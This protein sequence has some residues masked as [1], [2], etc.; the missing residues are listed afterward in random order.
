MPHFSDDLLL[1]RMHELCTAGTPFVAAT[2]IGTKG[3]TPRKVGAKML[4]ARDGRLFGTVGGGAVESAVIERAKKLF[5][6]PEVARL[7]WDLSGPEAGGM[8]CGGRMEFLLEPFLVRPRA[9]V[10]G[11]GHVGLALSR[12]LDFL[13][14]DVTVIDDREALMTPERFPHARL[15][16]QT[17]SEAALALDIPA[18]AYCIVV[19]RSHA[20]DLDTLRGLVRR[21]LRYVGLMSS[22][23][24]RGILLETLGKEGVAPDILKSVR[25]PVGLDI[26]A[27]TPEEIAVAIAAE[28]VGVLRAVAPAA[29]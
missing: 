9:F 18:D 24:K 3:S 2:V 23:R 16:Q 29:P 11:A 1:T 5:A 6:A 4:V 10:F 20:F 22:K 27:E 17:P 7:D 8:I 28:M 13:H 19:N 21:P 26:G 15:V 14:F 12:I 25:T